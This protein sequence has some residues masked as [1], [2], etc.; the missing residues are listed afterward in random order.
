M[1]VLGKWGSWD[2]GVSGTMEVLGQSKQ[3]IPV[4]IFTAKNRWQLKIVLWKLKTNSD[5]TN[6]LKIGMNQKFPESP[7]YTKSA[8]ESPL[9]DLMEEAS[10]FPMMGMWAR[11][12]G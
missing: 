6:T 9:V 7:N 11:M 3:D 5:L 8:P 4:N 10:D 1:G 2:N 12:R